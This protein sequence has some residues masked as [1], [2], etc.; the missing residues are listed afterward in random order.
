MRAQRSRDG[1]T[2]AAPPT[3]VFTAERLSR[4]WGAQAYLNAEHGRTPLHV[5]WLGR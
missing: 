4:I 2:E 3:E 1:P 5:A